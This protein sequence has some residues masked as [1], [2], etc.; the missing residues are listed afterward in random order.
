MNQ[1]AALPDNM[2]LL[3]SLLP[4]AAIFF[5][6]AIGVILLYA[7]FRRNIFRQVLIQREMESKHQKELMRTIVEAQETERKRIARDLHDDLG[8]LLSLTRMQLIHL[9]NQNS[10]GVP[11]SDLPKVRHNTELALASLRRLTHELMPPQLEYL[12][13]SKTLEGICD[14]LNLTNNI[15]IDL[16][17]SEELPRWESPIELALFRVSMELIN[18]TIKHSGGQQ[19]SLSISQDINSVCLTY[20][21]NGKGIDPTLPVDG[22]GLKNMEARIHA[23]GGEARIGN[24]ESGGFEA[25]FSI[26]TN[27]FSQHG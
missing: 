3:F 25:H 26:P 4:L 21:D 19:A 18:N 13:L 23:L 27:S 11:I 8:A 14:N 1:A 24:G 15:K 22:L 7:H 10:K 6:I 2:N 5:L 16:Q 9:E 20:T 12:G 17:A